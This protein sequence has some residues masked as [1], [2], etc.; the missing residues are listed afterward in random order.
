MKLIN[1]QCPNCG[2]KLSDISTDSILECPFCNSKFKIEVEI[3][4][5]IPENMQDV[6]YEFEKGRLRAQKDSKGNHKKIIAL[7]AGIVLMGGVL[8]YYLDLKNLNTD[9][10]LA[11]SEEQ[12][13]DSSSVKEEQKVVSTKKETS[14]KEDAVHITKDNVEQTVY[15]GEYGKVSVK[16]FEHGLIDGLNSYHIE[17]YVENQSDQGVIVYL[18]NTTSINDYQV[19]AYYTMTQIASEKK[20]TMDSWIYDSDIPDD[21]GDATEIDSEIVIRQGEEGPVLV[22]TPLTMDIDAATEV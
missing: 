19:G 21:I 7:I 1:L 9:D 11:R 22:S 4:P 16:K 18:P 10:S 15:N 13:V 12:S 3:K 20:G 17:F 5:Q 8:T 14:V 2:A 6:G